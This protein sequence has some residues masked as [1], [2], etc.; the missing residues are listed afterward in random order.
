MASLSGFGAVA[1]S[2]SLWLLWSVVIGALANQLPDRLLGRHDPHQ[3]DHL[4]AEPLRIYERWLGIRVWKPWIPD[5]GDALPGGIR[6]ASLA[7]RDPLALQRLSLETRRAELVHWALWPAWIV[8]AL[9]LPPAGVLINLIFATLFNLPCL[10]LQ[11]YNRLRL[12]RTLRRL[13]S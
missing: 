2:V 12:C 4:G 1:A 10:L 7:R 11:R 8:T 3:S 5:A 9:W 6:K 13:S